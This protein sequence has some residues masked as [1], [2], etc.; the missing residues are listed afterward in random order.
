MCR[1][2]GCGS[3]SRRVDLLRCQCEAAVWREGLSAVPSWWE[4]ERSF[5]LA[6]ARAHCD[7][8]VDTSAITPEETFRQVVEFCSIVR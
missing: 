4:E 8:Y 5:R 1:R 2:C 3:Q 7:L 6:H